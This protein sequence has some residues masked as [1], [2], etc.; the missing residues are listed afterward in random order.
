MT[1]FLTTSSGDRV[2]YDLRGEGPAVVFVAGAGPFREI[3][4]ETTATAELA[5]GLGL[6]T[7]VY[8]RL[9][10]GESTAA[11]P[12]PLQREIDALAALIDVAGSPAVLCGHS[13]GCTIALR[14]AVAGLPVA[15]LALWEIPLA[16]PGSGA[17]AW[18]AE[19]EGLLDDGQAAAAVE[20]YMRDMPPEFLAWLKDSPMW[21][22]FVANAAGLRPDAQALAWTDSAPAGDLWSGID[23]PA[24]VMTGSET[25]D[26]LTAG[27]DLAAAALRDARRLVVPG[28]QHSWEPE[29]MA[30]TLQG[31]VTEIAGR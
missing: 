23:A 17:A 10:R 28:A 7:L 2:A 20:T 26:E 6:T 1:E 27:A 25:F 31:F 19:V 24:L 29:A 8:D 15:G 30:K 5:T 18:A 14:A 9:G 11:A 12:I 21:P 13:S 4:P 3:D 16:P 22:A